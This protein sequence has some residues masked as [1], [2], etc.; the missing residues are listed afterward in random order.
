MYYV[1]LLISL[2]SGIFYIGQ[3]ENLLQRFLDHNANRSEF[4]KHK[5]PWALVAFKQFPS[6][7]AAMAEEYR[8]KKLKNKQRIL[9]EF[10]IEPSNIK[11]TNKE[12]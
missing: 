10:G 8:L 3:T 4:T 6:R 11:L 2:K 9:L 7:G 12:A 1:Y 5:G